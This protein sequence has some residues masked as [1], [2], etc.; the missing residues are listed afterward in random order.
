[1]VSSVSGSVSG[2]I[3]AQTPPVCQD[4]F[5]GGFGFSSVFLRWH[6]PAMGQHP[7]PEEH[8]PRFRFFQRC[9]TATAASAAT[10]P[11]TRSVAQLAAIHSQG[12]ISA[13]SFL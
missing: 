1:M 12:V 3:L 13:P 11:P 7:H 5:R 4:F 6:S 10:A 2:F 9:T 8:P